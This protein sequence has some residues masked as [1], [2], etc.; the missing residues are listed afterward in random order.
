MTRRWKVSLAV[1]VFAGALVAALR[2]GQPRPVRAGWPVNVGHRGAS[3]RFPENTLAS[4][5]AALEA[6]AGGLELDVRVTRDGHPVVMHDATVDRT[7]DGFGAVA[8]MTL[9]AV[10][11]LDTGTTGVPGERVPTLREIFEEFPA[12]PINIDIKD[13]D[14]PGAEKI[15][16]DV[17][18]EAG[19]A[20]RVLVA[21]ANHRVL[22]RF[23]RISGGEFDTGA[24][25]LEIAAF[26]ALNL[27]RLGR[28]ARPAYAAL[29]VPVDY[30]PLRILTPRFV[31]AAHAV[32]VRVDVW[33]INDPGRMRE[34][35]DLGAD[36]VM[37]DRPAALTEVLRGR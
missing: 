14:V 27:L 1:V 11:R 17:L 30:G 31:R 6:G 18:R 10:R 12:V 29:Q 34:V 16:L 32:G 5:R 28:L 3:V 2:R 9:E 24:S 13:R 15:V 4:F 37:T 23:R 33:T 21:S 22:Q 35:L 7:T 20:D 26:Y 8:G 36:G 19:A 25:R